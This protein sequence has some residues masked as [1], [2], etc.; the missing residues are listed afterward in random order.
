MD[1]AI[2]R[3]AIL[4]ACAL[5]VVIGLIILTRGVAVKEADVATME[6]DVKVIEEIAKTEENKAPTAHEPD[7]EAKASQKD[8]TDEA[9]Q[10]EEAQDNELYEGALA[11]LSEE[12]IAKLAMA[13]EQSDARAEMT[14]GKENAV[15]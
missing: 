6:S 8:V 12:E 13:E 9:L 2:K 10:H 1:P 4:L 11:G 15:D 7:E 14:D 3:V 5:I